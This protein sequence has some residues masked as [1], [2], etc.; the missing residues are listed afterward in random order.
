M[1]VSQ[2]ID[3]YVKNST[4]S[5]AN[6]SLMKQ[7]QNFLKS[8]TNIKDAIVSI[9]DNTGIAGFQFNITRM[10]Q[11][12]LS[13]DITDYY[14]DSNTVFN[15]H[16]AHKPVTVTVSGLQ[17]EYFYSVHKIKDMIS[18][19]GTT[20]KLVAA[21]KPQFDKI[22][23]QMR[24]KWESYQASKQ[25]NGVIGKA[26]DPNFTP[27]GLTLKEKLGFV[28]QAVF[29][30]NSVDLFKLFQSLYKFTSAQTRAYLFFEV[31]S[32]A[33]KP[34]TIETRWKRFDNM[35]IQ[36]VTVTGEDNADITEFQVTFKQLNF[37]HSEVVSINAAG[38]TQ[39]QYYE[40]ANKGID[41][42]TKLET[43]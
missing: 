22:Q 33:D 7:A 2:S 14:S 3:N 40:E 13:N 17:G 20:L 5:G 21:F 41:N 42:G 35:Y 28:K 19:I 30:Y 18:A 32:K 38:R 6:V 16:I 4:V 31:L 1:V 36:D 15:D 24:E 12:K 9:Y 25:T 37:T 11:V 43:I 27:S 29:S 39:Q 8:H 10:E 34:F 26:I 23:E